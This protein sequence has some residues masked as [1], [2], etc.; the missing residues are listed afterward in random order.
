MNQLDSGGGEVPAAY[1]T[2]TKNRTTA[3]VGET[4]SIP[5]NA[6]GITVSDLS[7]FGDTVQVSWLEP[8][9]IS[10]NVLNNELEINAIR[11]KYDD[12][13]PVALPPYAVATTLS[14]PV[15]SL[16][17]IVYWLQ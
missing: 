13:S 6:T 9:E 8:T 15:G 4:V 7:P 12:E 3:I 17:S 14:E 16:D 2:Y 1:S 5:G 10:G 11:T